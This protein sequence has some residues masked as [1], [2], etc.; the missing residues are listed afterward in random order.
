[1]PPFFPGSV[2]LPLTSCVFLLFALFSRLLAIRSLLLL[3]VCALCSSSLSGVSSTFVS[4]AWFERG[5]SISPPLFSCSCLFF[6]V[7]SW[8]FLLP[9]LTTQSS[10][11]LAALLGSV[12][13]V[14][15]SLL[16]LFVRPLLPFSSPWA[17][18]P[19][20]CSCRVLFSGSVGVPLPARWLLVSS[21]W[22]FS[23]FRL[24]TSAATLLVA[25]TSHCFF[26]CCWS[27]CPA[28]GSS[29][30]RILAICSVCC[31]SFLVC[32]AA[33]LFSVVC[34]LVW[35]WPPPALA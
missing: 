12:Y 25:V 20:A 22:G 8:C 13:P 15:H 14:H 33:L 26:L 32:R 23:S 3:L 17:S 4:L 9:S 24:C 30:L 35:L 21:F 1:M 11:A 7:A 19:G 27:A 6:L 29:G 34:R 31:S 16:A 2:C 18:V 5:H 28:G 10:V